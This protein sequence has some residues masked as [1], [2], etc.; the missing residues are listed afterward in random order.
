MKTTY[1]LCDTL[2]LLMVETSATEFNK[3]SIKSLAHIYF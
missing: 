1:K 2:L 3:L